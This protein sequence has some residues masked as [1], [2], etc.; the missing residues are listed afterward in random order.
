MFSISPLV[1]TSP[2]AM[3]AV[4]VARGTFSLIAGMEDV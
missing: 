2:P 4:A 1:I 3:P